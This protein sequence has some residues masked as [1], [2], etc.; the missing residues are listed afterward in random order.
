EGAYPLN[1]DLLT[2]DEARRMM[3]QR[4]GTQQVSADPGAVDDLIHRCARLPLALAVVAARAGA[5][6]AA[7][8]R[9]LADELSGSRTALQALAGGE[10]GTDVASVF[11]WS[12]GQLSPGAARLFRLLGLQPGPDCGSAAAASLAGLPPTAVRGHL[13][14]LTQANLL[15]EHHA[16][17][18]AF[19]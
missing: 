2:V 4:L 14:E 8:L 12:Y 18:Y 19:H 17:R 6:P 3:R 9:A 13:T 10:R 15:S 11:S 16:G 1:L 5:D 7:P